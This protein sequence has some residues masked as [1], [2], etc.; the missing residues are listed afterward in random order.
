MTELYTDSEGKY[1]DPGQEYIF[2]PGK[3]KEKQRKTEIKA[4]SDQ[5]PTQQQ[6]KDHNKEEQADLASQTQSQEEENKIL[7]KGKNA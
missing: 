4:Q 3:N 1:G 7:F 2:H 6:T 5:K